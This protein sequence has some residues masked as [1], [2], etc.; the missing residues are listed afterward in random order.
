MIGITDNHDVEALASSVEDVF[1]RVLV[2]VDGSPASLEATRQAGR[3]AAPGGELALGSVYDYASEISSIG[4]GG[5]VPPV[6]LDKDVLR[7]RTAGFL[8]DARRVLGDDP[9][10]TST[11]LAGHPSQALLEEADRI[12]ATAI[13]V[14]T[15]GKSRL[16][17]IVLGSTASEVVHDAP[18]SVLVA[19]STVSVPPATIVVGVDGSTE[20]VRALAVARS[21]CSRLGARLWPVV[22]HGGDGV[23]EAVV[24]RVLQ[25]HRHEDVQDDPVTALVAAGADAGLVVVGSR[26]LRGLHALGSVSERVAH[27]A[28]CSVLVVR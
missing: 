6:V 3:L 21:L 2:G 1:A 28:P 20:S 4:A 9:R 13:A 18:C 15:H 16:R 11:V 14:G 10:V 22:A 23:D 25:V 17:G 8:A 26:G 27:Q 7:D 5:F 24:R 19:R 12:D